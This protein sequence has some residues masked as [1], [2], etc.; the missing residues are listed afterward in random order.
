MRIRWTTDAVEDLEQIALRIRK[1]NATA[2]R[3]VLRTITAGI[4]SLRK[5]PRRGRIGKLEG[6]RELVLALLPYIAVYRVKIEAATASTF[7]MCWISA[8]VTLV[9]LIMALPFALFL[10]LLSKTLGLQA[11]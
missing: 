7:E 5:F 10:H 8:L 6:S 1:D 3:N 9:A 11:H 4:S 2:A